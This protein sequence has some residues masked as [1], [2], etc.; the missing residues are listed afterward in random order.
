M[1][2]NHGRPLLIPDNDILAHADALLEHPL[3]LPTDSRLIASCELLI[4]RGEQTPQPWLTTVP[5]FRA[6]IG[7]ASENY[8]QALRIFNDGAPG[9][10]RRWTKYY[11]E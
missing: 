7:E 5:L 6:A 8:D 10:E 2:Y 9:W 4:L 3:S 11:R 1:S